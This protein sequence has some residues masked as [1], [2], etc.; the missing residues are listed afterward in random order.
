METGGVREFIG[1]VASDRVEVVVEGIYCI[2]P[3]CVCQL[4]D[5]QLSRCCSVSRSEVHYSCIC[6]VL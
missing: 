5:V 3:R 4:D 6:A 1:F 2:E